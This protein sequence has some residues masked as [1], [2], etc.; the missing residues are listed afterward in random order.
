M[1][2][3]DGREPEQQRAAI[4]E[5]MRDYDQEVDEPVTEPDQ[6]VGLRLRELVWDRL[7]PALSDCTHLLLAPDGALNR[8]PFEVLPLDDGRRVIDAYQLS[9][10][11]VGRDLLRFSAPM[12]NQFAP[13]LVIADPN[14]GYGAPPE[15]PATGPFRRLLG[16]Q[17]EANR[18][19][20]LLEVAPVV[21]DEALDGRVKAH[22]A[23]GHSPRMLHL[24]THG[25][26]LPTS[27]TILRASRSRWTWKIVVVMR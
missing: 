8:L 2:R 10:V 27:P 3:G 15:H 11:S 20:E 19:A 17:T 25:F 23:P 1:V 22:L 13:P 18:L 9:Y 14:F 7:R 5:A 24:A 4:I 12:S 6:G 21:G 16:T 26:F